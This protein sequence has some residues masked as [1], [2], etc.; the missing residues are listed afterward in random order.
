MQNSGQARQK[1]PLRDLMRAAQSKKKSLFRAQ[2]AFL[3]SSLQ[4]SATSVP[5]VD[6]L[7]LHNAATHDCEN[8]LPADAHSDS[9]PKPGSGVSVGPTV[10]P[11]LPGDVVAE[12]VGT[13]P[14]ALQE[15]AGGEAELRKHSSQLVA[16]ANAPPG[17][18]AAATVAVADP[19]IVAGAAA[20]SHL[21]AAT[22]VAVAADFPVLAN[23]ANAG[24]CSEQLLYNGGPG[25]EGPS[26]TVATSQIGSGPCGDGLGATV[27]PSLL[28]TVCAGT[29]QAVVRPFSFKFRVIHNVLKKGKLVLPKSR[30]LRAGLQGAGD[31]G[32]ISKEGKEPHALTLR[33]GQVPVF[34][35][36]LVEPVKQ[37]R[38][39]PQQGQGRPGEIAR[40]PE[41]HEQRVQ[42]RGPSG[43]AGPATTV[44]AAAVPKA[45]QEEDY[46]VHIRLPK[47]VL[48]T[49]GLIVDD[50]LQFER[51]ADGSYRLTAHTPEGKPKALALAMA[52]PEASAALGAV[53]PAAAGPVPHPSSGATAGAGNGGA[54]FPSGT[55][56]SVG[57][58][59]SAD[60]AARATHTGSSPGVAALEGD[61]I[62]GG[63]TPTERG[64]GGVAGNVSVNKNDGAV[65][66]HLDSGVKLGSGEEEPSSLAIGLRPS[67]GGKTGNP[68]EAWGGEQGGTDLLHGAAAALGDILGCGGGSERL[69]MHG[70]QQM[71]GAAAAA[72]ATATAPVVCVTPLAAAAIDAPTGGQGVDIGQ[73]GSTTAVKAFASAFAT[74]AVQT[75]A[76]SKKTS[77]KAIE[78]GSNSG[79]GT[80]PGRRQ[81]FVDSRKDTAPPPAVQGCGAEDSKDTAARGRAAKNVL[82]PSNELCCKVVSLNA[83]KNRQLYLTRALLGPGGVFEGLSPGP[84][85]FVEKGGERSWRLRFRQSGHQY[86]H[87]ITPCKSML[88]ALGITKEECANMSVEL[89]FAA[90]ADPTALPAAVAPAMDA[91]ASGATASG[92]AAVHQVPCFTVEAKKLPHWTAKTTAKSGAPF[93]S[94]SKPLRMSSQPSSAAPKPRWKVA[95]AEAA[96]VAADIPA[97]DEVLAP[98]PGPLAPANPVDPVRAAV[99][100]LTLASLR[101]QTRPHLALERLWISTGELEQ[102]GDSASA[103]AAAPELKLCGV[104]FTAGPAAAQARAGAT[105]WLAR[106]RHAAASHGAYG[107][108]SP[109]I[110]GD[111]EIPGLNAAGRTL[112]GWHRKHWHA[113]F[114]TVK[115]GLDLDPGSKCDKACRSS[116]GAAAVA[117]KAPLSVAALL[118]GLRE[119]VAQY[120]DRNAAP[121]AQQQQLEEEER[122]FHHGPGQSGGGDGGRGVLPVGPIH[123]RCLRACRDE[124]RGGLGVCTDAAIAAGAPVGVLPGCTLQG[125]RHSPWD[126]DGGG[127]GG[128]GRSASTVYGAH[129]KDHG[130]CDAAVYARDGYKFIKDDHLKEELRRRGGGDVD[131]A[132]Q[133]LALSY[134]FPYPAELSE[135]A[136]RVRGSVVGGPDGG[137]SAVTAAGGQRPRPFVLCMLGHG[138]VLS[139][140]NDPSHISLEVMQQNRSSTPQPPRAAAQA[141][142][143]VIPA[144]YHG[145]VLPVVVT[146][147][148]LLPGDQLL[149]DYSMGWWRELADAWEM[150]TEF[151]VDPSQLLHE[152]GTFEAVAAPPQPPLDVAIAV[153]PLPLS[154]LDLP[155]PPPPPPPPLPPLPLPTSLLIPSPPTDSPPSTPPPLPPPSPPPPLPKL[156]P[157][158]FPPLPTLP[159]PP[160]PDPPLLPTSPRPVTAAASPTLQPFSL[161]PP[162][163]G[164][165]S[166]SGSAL[167]G[168]HRSATVPVVE[169]LTP[170]QVL[171]RQQPHVPPS[172]ATEG[173][174]RNK[175]CDGGKSPRPKESHMHKRPRCKSHDRDRDR[176]RT[177]EGKQDRCQDGSRDFNGRQDVS[178]SPVYGRDRDGR[179]HREEHHRKQDRHREQERAKQRRSRSRS[180]SRSHSRG[181]DRGHQ[182]CHDY[183][184]PRDRDFRDRI[185]DSRDHRDGARERETGRSWDSPRDCALEPDS[186]RKWKGA[187]E[188][189]ERGKRRTTEQRGHGHK[190]HGQVAKPA[191][192]GLAGLSLDPAGSIFP[193]P[194]VGSPP[195]GLGGA[196]GHVNA[197]AEPSVYCEVDEIGKTDAGMQATR[198]KVEERDQPSKGSAL[199]PAATPA[200]AADPAGV[201]TSDAETA[202]GWASSSGLAAVAPPA[203]VPVSSVAVVP[204]TA[205]ADAHGT[206]SPYAA[207]TTVARPHGLRVPE[208]S[209]PTV[210]DS[211]T[212]LAQPQ[213]QQEDPEQAQP[214]LLLSD[215][216]RIPVPAPA[217]D[218]D[219]TPVLSV[220][221]APPQPTVQSLLTALQHALQAV[222]TG[223]NVSASGLS[224]TSESKVSEEG[225]VHTCQQEAPI[226][227]TEVQPEMV[228]TAVDVD[229]PIL[230]QEGS[231]RLGLATEGGSD[232]VEVSAVGEAANNGQAFTTAGNGRDRSDRKQSASKKSRLAG[233]SG[234][235]RPYDPFRYSP[236]LAN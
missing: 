154:P 50:I 204:P 121:H 54:E 91:A 36:L 83:W 223:A 212:Q 233:N 166:G 179:H 38:A 17:S 22:A 27:S 215:L 165:M 29:G 194:S 178:R 216:G 235:K 146:L 182:T 42:E 193:P 195:G 6:G 184:H 113:L 205:A 118:E 230:K 111:W 92:T 66:R 232:G 188:T 94:R 35:V 78:G 39:Q 172:A 163:K 207:A 213:Q 234:S 199:A 98:G 151:G 144:A 101:N 218:P 112:P 61:C 125:R 77:M 198:I 120:R 34:F 214:Q 185:T 162:W 33:M 52:A 177:R 48:T 181:R 224:Q 58:D 102:V 134:Q 13:E 3:A 93:V 76:R 203:S 72:A 211:Q 73:R 24:A 129:C 104:L 236:R 219:L 56:C 173:R 145:V 64:S 67:G 227:V 202:P 133:F 53:A 37:Q 51:L 126:E 18:L 138:G 47:K 105:G 31:L 136:A 132:W 70:P 137:D 109:A 127:G 158:D 85:H 49:A 115:P 175:V 171:L 208:D 143:V 141:N 23:A 55:R 110:C 206:V 186:G 32:V 82:T 59:P 169:L 197:A 108:G 5:G 106:R 89:V 176:S 200:T 210:L 160:L 161:R 20:A 139:L 15:S 62:P 11:V 164:S 209:R 149:L 74:A 45:A 79:K 117:T 43:G 4:T 159:P 229:A 130:A 75:S 1:V 80:L 86:C 40:G 65:E 12:V 46:D 69:E 180:R 100:G 119:L 71:V 88:A 123:L 107:A 19:P 157:L 84:V 192:P 87:Y 9:A 228:A 103:Q 187:K 63:P 57:A 183:R 90:I 217:A 114:T 8:G 68:P 25:G 222:A 2:A 81:P 60:P 95:K 170:S 153:A 124:A 10:A 97:R 231:Q 189:K 150:A 44:A 155:A 221:G 226:T 196:A 225:R 26:V 128:G 174:N 156:P 148:P 122:D 201:L 41:G 135:V 116:A 190:S 131:C 147:Q 220:T 168:C 21:A 191:A 152:P 30:L 7:S 96:A 99:E 140:I 14:P 142:C 167:D 28:G 16:T